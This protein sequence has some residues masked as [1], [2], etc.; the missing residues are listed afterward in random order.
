LNAPETLE[1]F[2]AI[3][4]LCNERNI[5]TLLNASPH[6]FAP[7][8]L[9]TPDESTKL[10]LPGFGESLIVKP[11]VARNHFRPEN[12]AAFCPVCLINDQYHR[13]TWS[14]L[15]QTAC[16]T[17]NCLLV[18]RCQQCHANLRIEDIVASQCP[19]C[20][21]DLRNSLARA[22]NSDQIGLIA[23]SILLSWFDNTVKPLG[24]Y[25]MPDAIP[26]VLY[27]LFYGLRSSVHLRTRW[28]FLHQLP[29]SNV[30]FRRNKFR[31]KQDNSVELQYRHNVTALKALLDWPAGF[32]EFAEH[33]RDKKKKRDIAIGLGNLYWSWIE[34]R[35]NLPQFQFV[36]EA[37]DELLV[38]YNEVLLPNIHKARRLQKNPELA[39]RFNYISSSYAADILGVSYQTVDRYVEKGDITCINKKNRDPYIGYIVLQN[40]VYK[41]RDIWQD[42]LSLSEACQ[43]IGASKH[44][45]IE[46]IKG[47]CLIA[48]RGKTTDGHA[49]WM[50]SKSSLET[51]HRQIRESVIFFDGDKRNMIPFTTLLQRLAG[52]NTDAAGLVKKLTSGEIKGYRI[53]GD[54]ERLDNIYFPKYAVREIKTMIIRENGWIAANKFANQAG[55]KSSTVKA[56]I[57]SGLITPIATVGNVTF[58]SQQEANAFKNKY[59]DTKSAA[60]ILKVGIQTVQKWTRIGRLNPISGKDLNGCHD[61]LFLREDIMRYRSES[62]ISVPEMAIRLGKSKSTVYEWIKKGKLTPTSGPG[63]DGAKHYLFLLP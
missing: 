60:K 54:A 12:E 30:S 31:S 34:N 39:R 13:L 53:A 21:F 55:V 50:I 2:Y 5:T 3:A 28:E 6:R 16:I 44:H 63:I 24:N 33:Y 41:L 22:V 56:W 17:H 27:Q 23:Q 43:C 61:Y 42:T 46:L 49:I 51:L 47:G 20:K 62:R 25:G 32:Y 29:D 7:I 4:E 14:L 58:L 19:R 37:Y 10:T 35:W 40:D 45:I 36:Q 48:P 9:L 8:I 1:A 26:A 59:A 52:W 11:E 38:R 57:A 18:D 15:A